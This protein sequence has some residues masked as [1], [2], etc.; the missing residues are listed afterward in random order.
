MPISNNTSRYNVVSQMER[1]ELGV[2]SNLTPME[3]KALVKQQK[4]VQ[5]QQRTVEKADSKE[6]YKKAGIVLAVV[7]IAGGA[8][9]G[10][11]LCGKQTADKPIGN[12]NTTLPNSNSTLPRLNS[13]ALAVNSDAT[14]GMNSISEV[15]GNTTAPVQNHNN[16]NSQV[17][18]KH[19]SRRDFDFGGGFG[20][21]SSFKDSLN[22]GSIGRTP[23][24][25]PQSQQG[26]SEA[27][28]SQQGLS[29]AAQSQQGLSEAAQTEQNSWD[30]QNKLGDGLNS[31]DD[32]LNRGSIGRNPSKAAQSQQG[33][34]EAA[35]SQPQTRE[36]AIAA[37][38]AI[39]TQGSSWENLYH[40]WGEAEKA[41]ET[42]VGPWDVKTPEPTTTPTTTTTT[43]EV[44][45]SSSFQVPSWMRDFM[46][47][48]GLGGR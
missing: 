11:A 13:T 22:R 46:S 40:S 32:S 7:L 20:D 5:F 15:Q 33:L 3:R 37:W 9:A 19:R 48:F 25:A 31:F 29:E 43:T 41:W 36:E 27:S 47:K 39:Y 8:V 1:G 6:N 24:K 38:E 23:S 44:P 21:M 14:P 4:H 28:Q 17:K 30:S 35:P 18:A 16:S 45:F 34:S 10:A 2:S 12:R 26:L 42:M